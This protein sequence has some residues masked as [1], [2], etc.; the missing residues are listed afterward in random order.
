MLTREQ[1]REQVEQ[2]R[3]A[4]E[5]VTSVF[6]L[7]NTGLKVNEVNELRAKVR[8]A[9]A[10]YKVVKNSV[11]R[12]AVEGT[13]MEGLSPFLAGPNAI[14]FSGGDAAALARV[15]RDFAK[16]HPAL[17]FQRACLEGQVVDSDGARAIAD[18]PSRAELVSKL[19][20]VLQSP[21]RR[22]VVALNAPTSQLAVAL[23]QIAEQK[24]S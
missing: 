9:S 1:K 17:T 8:A 14:A 5:G 4:L 22:L 16:T 24:Q 13:A 12:L 21:I 2:L 19:L 11:V 20:Y 6:L 18:L 15:L 3:A 23:N 7:A 10:T